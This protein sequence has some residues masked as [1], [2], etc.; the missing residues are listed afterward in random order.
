MAI[1]SDCTLSGTDFVLDFISCSILRTDVGSGA[2]LGI[3]LLFGI[4]LSTFVISKAYSFERAFVFS[5]LLGVILGSFMTKFGWIPS[6]VL[7]LCIAL[8]VIAI[9]FLIKERS[10]YE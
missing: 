10:P 7:Y 8:L 2:V 1:F 3:L 9:F 6:K 5:S 4:M